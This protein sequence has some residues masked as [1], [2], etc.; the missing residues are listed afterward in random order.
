M[1]A[2]DEAN[3][4]E[5][6]RAA[7]FWPLDVEQEILGRTRE[8]AEETR[9]LNWFGRARRR[10]LIDFCT[11]MSF[12]TKVG[13][14]LIQALQVARQDCENERFRNVL[15]GLQ[16]HIESGLLFH[17]ALEKYPKIFSL[18][19]TSVVRA[20]ELSSKLPETF[21]DLKRY[22]EWVENVIAEIRQASL[23]P[24]IVMTVVAGFV[25]FLFSY[26][27]PQ[28][29]ELLKAT[30]APLPLVTQII[31]GVSDF[32]KATWWFWAVLLVFC[33]LGVIIGRRISKRFAF[34]ADQVKIKLPIFGELNL[35]LS[36]SRFT[37]NLAILY[38]SGIPII[39]AFQLCEDLVGNVVVEKAVAAVAEGLKAG[40]IISEAMRKREVF[41]SML[42]Q[43]VIMG[44]TTGNLDAALDNV[45]DYYNQIIPRRIKKIFTIMEP[46]LIVFLI[47]IVGAVALSIFLPII[48]LMG[49]IS[50]R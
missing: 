35:M 6:L 28:F 8:K 34:W 27:I 9:W 32:A 40:E 49:S 39:Q 17:E 41:P 11:I 36:I 25:L 19:F 29:A 20:G 10:D 2:N 21:V 14:P 45:A 50:K 26:I 1:P 46:A 7:G 3:L 37:H 16:R 43:M 30:N 42:M 31:F 48:S 24:M 4:E 47:F 12:Q 23:Y 38:R 18:H 13:I 22:L 5:K 15:Q 33:S 44:E